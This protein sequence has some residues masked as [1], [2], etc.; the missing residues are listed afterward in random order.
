MKNLSTMIIV[1]GVCGVLAFNPVAADDG[2]GKKPPAKP[3]QNVSE[4][5]VLPEFIP[6]LGSLYVDPETLPAGPF[7][8]YDQNE[9]LVSTVYMIPLDQ[10][11][12][13]EDF[14]EL[15]ATGRH[16]VE[17]DV[18]YNAG[19]PG[20]AEPHYHIVLWHVPRAKASL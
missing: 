12:S 3:F 2:F 19:H 14:A 7:L 10:L 15:G 8:A 18:V 6:G 4:L 13:N 20:V 11:N 9:A 17:T 16:V 1:A 5:V